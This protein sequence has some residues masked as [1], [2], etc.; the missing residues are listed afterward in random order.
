MSKTYRPYEP[1][2][3]FLM[4]PSLTDWLPGDHMVYFVRELLDTIDLSPIM[5][6][7]ED[8]ERGYPPYHPKV[9]TGILLYGYANGL[10]SSRKLARHCREDVAFRV[11]AANNQP[12][13]RTISDFR[14]LHLRTLEHLFV[15]ILQLCCKAGLVKFGHIALDG[16]KIKANASKHKAMSYGRMKQE[17]ER[18]RKEIS[19]LLLQAEATDARED[20]QYGADKRGDE[21]PG[22][23]AHRETRLA[24][25]KEAKR[26]L[27]EE[28]REQAKK[29]DTPQPPPD[30]QMPMARVKTE[31][32][33]HTGKEEVADDAQRNFTDPDSRIMPYQKTFVQGYNAQ[34]AVDSAHQI[35]VATDVSNTPA[36]DPLLPFMVSRLKKKPK[37]LSADAGYSVSDENL[38]YLKKKRIDGYIAIKGQKHDKWK[39]PSQLSVRGRIPDD[40]TIKQLM[41]RKLLTNKGRRVYTRRKC[42]AEPPIGQIKHVQGFRQF[43]LRGYFNV[44]AEWFLVTATHNL[45]KLFRAC[46]T[47]PKRRAF[48]FAP[49]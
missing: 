17:T 2:Q 27:E 3:L 8:E 47:E 7:Y 23:L 14:K 32:D 38:K 35:I 30:K 26:A 37:A 21:L 46:W 48:L 33:T 41:K 11:L 39:H 9:M 42:I 15:E 44:R 40:L 34:V 5:A 31:R 22:E 24:R 10:T 45:R 25:I 28:A 13:H 12:D 4:P 19:Q 16:T 20:R 36:D 18:L 29:D 43:S 49:A 6:V 1:D